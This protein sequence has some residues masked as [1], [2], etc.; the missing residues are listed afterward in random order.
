VRVAGIGRAGARWAGGLVLLTLAAACGGPIGQNPGPTAAAVGPAALGVDDTAAM[1]HMEALQ[2]IADE[3]DGNRAQGTSGYDASVDYVV[4]RLRAAG[5]DVATPEY[6]AK[7]DDDDD[8]DDNGGDNGGGG[9]GGELVRSRNVIAQTRGGDPNHVV[10]IGAHLDSVPKGPGIVDDGSGVAAVLEIAARLAAAPP[11]GNAVRFA[12][13]GSEESGALGSAAYVKSLSSAERQKIMLYLN[14]DMVASPN[15]GYL[16]QGGTGKDADETGPPGSADVAQVLSDQLSAT[17]AKPEKIKFVGD[18]EAAFLDAGIPS[19]GA[20]NGD[21]K[22]KTDAQ[23]QEW[24]GQAGEVYDHC[25]HQAC[26]RIDNVNRVVFAH[27]LRAIAGTVAHFASADNRLA[28][29]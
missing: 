8:D 28:S 16:V 11:T 4:G 17:G 29:R 15:A 21:A 24:G 27:Y 14:V 6:E 25:Y 5:L 12:F 10:V 26:D 3:H 19:A 20:E 1:A 13:F 18:D 22:K 9:R 23:A 2:K 7:S